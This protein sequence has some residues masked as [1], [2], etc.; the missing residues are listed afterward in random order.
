MHLLPFL[1]IIGCGVAVNNTKAVL[2]ALLNVQSGFVRTPKLAVVKAGDDFKDKHYKIPL[3]I[4]AFAEIFMGFYCLFGVWLYLQNF[5][6]LVGPFLI[7]YTL[8]F[9]YVAVISFLHSRRAQSI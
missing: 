9:S 6:F 2:E 3:N 5:R 7:V 8:G 4:V 1:I